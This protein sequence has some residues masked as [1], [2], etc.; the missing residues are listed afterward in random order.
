MLYLTDDTD[1]SGDFATQAEANITLQ[2]PVIHVDRVRFGDGAVRGC[3][4]PLAPNQW[5]EAAILLAHA[6]C[7]TGL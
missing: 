7:A 5:N 1:S 6:N 3:T 2:P 4:I